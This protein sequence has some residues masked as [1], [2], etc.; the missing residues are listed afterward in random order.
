MFAQLAAKQTDKSVFC[1]YI[2]ILAYS[3][4]CI[5]QMM[6]LCSV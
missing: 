5:F 3:L 4:V 2:I 1:F 6:Y